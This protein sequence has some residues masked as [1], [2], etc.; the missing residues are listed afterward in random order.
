MTINKNLKT[1]F[2]LKFT[3]S[4]VVTQS[5]GSRQGLKALQVGEIDLAAVSRSL[6]PLLQALAAD[7]IGYATY[8]QVAAQ[9]TIWVLSVQPLF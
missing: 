8:S 4:R 6:T 1:S 7:G 9:T 3:G 5:R 2:E